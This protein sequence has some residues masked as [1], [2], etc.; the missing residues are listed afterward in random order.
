MESLYLLG[1]SLFPGIGPALGNKLLHRFGSAES[2]WKA[3]REDFSQVV[4][5]KRTG[6]FLAFRD[7]INLE[8]EKEKIVQKG[9]HLLTIGDKEYPTLL[10]ELHDSAPFLL[11]VKGDMRIFSESKSMGVVGTRKITP[12]G[13]EVTEMITRDL[14]SAGWVIVSGLAFGVDATAHMTAVRNHGKTIAVLGCGVDCC[15]PTSNQNIYNAILE[16]GGAIV[17]AFPPGM[18]ATIGT[19]PARNALIAGLSLGILVTEGAADSG[20]LITAADA[21]KFSRPIFAV[22]GQITSHLSQGANNLLKDGAIPVTHARDI[23]ATLY[24]SSEVEKFEK[25]S[26]SATTFTR[27][28]KS[29]NLEEQNILNLL[30]IGPL[31]FDEIVRRIGKDSKYLGSLLSLMELKGII[32]SNS[33]G[34]YSV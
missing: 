13:R 9:I 6:K 24:S 11:Y 7:S 17:S 18:K 29:D 3:P 31:H 2:A 32:K 21:K 25:D 5:E 27:T 15:T 20:A 19:F 14:V 23:I 8:K 10:K 28:I 26:S 34:T 12:Y 1:F 16:N 4:G 30:E 33:N 22:P